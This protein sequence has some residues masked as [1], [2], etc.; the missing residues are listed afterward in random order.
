[1]IKDEVAKLIKTVQRDTVRG[2]E[3]L[4]RLIAIGMPAVQLIIDEIRKRSESS[5]LLSTVLL[6]IRHPDVVPVFIDLLKEDNTDLA[7]MAF[8]GLGQSGDRRALQPLLDHLLDPN[9]LTTDRAMAAEA[10]G[11]L[12]DQRAT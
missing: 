7:M 2:H 12:G 1:M 10:L 4:G 3:A 6:Q 9:N 11:E 8:K 5:W